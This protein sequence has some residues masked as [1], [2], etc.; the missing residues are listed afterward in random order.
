MLLLFCIPELFIYFV[1]FYFWS[2][3]SENTMKKNLAGI[4]FNLFFILF[5][6]STFHKLLTGERDDVRWH[7]ARHGLD[8]DTG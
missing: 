5:Y 2:F 4:F 7:D 1:K 8:I 3:L 6:F